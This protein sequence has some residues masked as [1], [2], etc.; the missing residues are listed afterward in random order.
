MKRS[1]TAF[2]ISE[3]L[4][5]LGLVGALVTIGFACLITMQ[6]GFVYLSAWSDI[7]ANQV[8]LLDAMA[9][10]LRTAYSARTTLSGTTSRLPLTIN[11]LQGYSTYETVTD[12]AGDPGRNVS[13]LNNPSVSTSNLLVL[14]GTA[15]VTYTGTITGNTQTIYRSITWVE[16]GTRSATRAVA[17]F[18][19]DMTI[20]FQNNLGGPYTNETGIIINVTDR[21]TERTRTISSTISNSV[22]LRPQQYLK[23][24]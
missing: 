14:G 20:F 16:S 22:F 12:R 17:T 11:L 9:I 23:L 3:M 21:F 13:I 4:V 18:S 24:R 5:T 6:R 19:K 7:R 10:D 2:T 1:Q 15:T 8:R